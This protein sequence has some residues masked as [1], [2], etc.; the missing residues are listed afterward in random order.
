MHKVVAK[1]ISRIGENSGPM[2]RGDR[3]LIVNEHESQKV[4]LVANLAVFC[5]THR[6]RDRNRCSVPF[7]VIWRGSR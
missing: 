7:V 5:P 3:G 6:V 1:V 4:T 2:K